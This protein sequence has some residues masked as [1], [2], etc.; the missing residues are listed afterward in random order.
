MSR[1]ELPDDLKLSEAQ[2]QAIVERALR[3][4]PASTLITMAQL[5]E[6]AAELDIDQSAL[7]AAARSV[8]AGSAP[9]AT[10]DVGVAESLLRK[11]SRARLGRAALLC[12]FT[13]ALGVFTTYVEAGGLDSVLNRTTMPGSGSFVD[14]P[15]GVFLIVLT[16][17]NAYS[18]LRFGKRIQFLVE[19]VAT[20]LGFAAGWTLG[21]G[22][23]TADLA[24]FVALTLAGSVLLTW[25]RLH[26]GGKRIRAALAEL[27]ARGDAAGSTSENQMR[28]DR[29]ETFLD[30][31]RRLGLH[32]GSA[33]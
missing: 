21:N 16:L 14:V 33:G 17:V 20:W 3:A 5:R 10:V 23:L 15:V 12:A 4:P 6:I 11:A 22:G 24:T 28:R 26:T 30:A 27:I 2:V 25:K 29:V 8:L 13:A 7:A 19:S 1:N 18:R 9:S 31:S 32:P